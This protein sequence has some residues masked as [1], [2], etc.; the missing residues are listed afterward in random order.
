MS[1]LKSKERM[2]LGVWYENDGKIT[3]PK[4]KIDIDNENRIKLELLNMSRADQNEI[5]ED[6]VKPIY[7]DDYRVESI[8][9][10]VRVYAPSI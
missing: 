8:I 2:L 1:K 9:G 3:T 6:T 10:G 5:I 7:G 4:M